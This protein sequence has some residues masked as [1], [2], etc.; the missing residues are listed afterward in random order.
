MPS[1][2]PS[3]RR[4]DVRP[5]HAYTIVQVHGLGEAPPLANANF[6]NQIGIVYVDGVAPGRDK[7][8]DGG[9]HG[10][11]QSR[12]KRVEIGVVSLEGREHITEPGG[13]IEV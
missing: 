3:L 9:L 8:K 12:G 11:E 7:G 10:R 13:E 2:H 4:H 1:P 6:P 5:E